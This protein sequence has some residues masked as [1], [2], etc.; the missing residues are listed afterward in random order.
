MRTVTLS[1]SGSADVVTTISDTATALEVRTAI[2]NVLTAAATSGTSTNPATVTLSAGEFIV[3]AVSLA[4]SQGVLRVGSNTV[5]QGQGMQSSTAPNPT[6]VKLEA[7][8]SHD[9]TGIIR[10]E[11]STPTSNVQIKNLTVD[12]NKAGLT[13]STLK[14]DGIY[15]GPVPGTALLVD[16]N[17][18][19]DGVEIRN[20]SR[21]GFDPHEQ[22]DQLVIKNSVSHHNGLDGFTIDFCTNVTLENN[23]SYANGQNGFNIVTSSNNV[24]LINNKAYS[25]S[26]S[27][28]AVQAGQNEARTITHDVRIVGGEVYGNSG[29]GI[30]VRQAD[31]VTV[32][33]NSNGTANGVSIHGNNLAG[34]L[35]EGS[36]NVSASNNTIGG[37]S[38]NPGTSA[39][40]EVRVKGYKQTYGDGDPANDLFRFS[41]GVAI[42]NNAIGTPVV[43]GETPAV[44][45]ISYTADVLNFATLPSNVFS[46]VTT[47][48][49]SPG[50]TQQDGVPLYGYSISS[51]ND[52]INGTAGA[53]IIAADSGNDIVNGLAGNDTL[54]GNDG[55]DILQGGAGA[56]NL[57]GGAGSDTASYAASASGVAVNLAANTASG[58]EA[59]GDIFTSIENLS[60]S[61]FADTLT[62][63]AG[64]N[65]IEGGAGDDVLTG[66]GNA[67][68]GDTVSYANSAAGITVSLA[69]LTLQGTKGAGFDTISGF[70]NLTGSAFADTLTGDS[71]NNVISGGDGDDIVDGG[72]GDDTLIA[73]NGVDT[74]SY[75]TAA[76]GVTISLADAAQ[77]ATGGAGNDKISDFENIV[78]SDFNDMLI[79][80]IGKN[81]RL[82]G[83]KG[84]DFYIVQDIGD[85]VFEQFG[86]G[87]DEVLASFSYTLENNV[88]DLLLGGSSGPINGTGNDSN[89]AL[90]GND[91]DNSL[92]GGKGD[93]YLD[94]QSGNDILD[95]GTGI[96]TMLG[97]WGNDT[98]Y[99]DNGLDSINELYGQGIDTVISSANFG[100]GW[101]T[102]EVENLTLTGTAFEAI[103]NELNNTLT[104]NSGNNLLLGSDGNDTLIGGGGNDTLNGGDGNDVLYGGAGNDDLF[105]GPNADR[106]VFNTALNAGTNNDDILDFELIDRIDVSRTFFVGIGP[107]NTTLTSDA[108]WTGTKAN[109]AQDRIIYTKGSNVSYLYYDKDGTGAQAAPVL[110]ARID[111]NIAPTHLDFFIIA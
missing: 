81:N 13:S 101:F 4:A 33:I 76:S 14:V 32:G 72:L 2:Q 18:T 82:S 23:T 50:G 85:V 43:A 24:T 46:G 58:G 97:G 87:R 29:S 20:M 41:D 75:A 79:G 56:D 7:G 22:T 80:A 94:G 5:F 103:G 105:G 9:V 60:G 16:S 73:G 109:D 27:G 44:I 34:L 1:V 111:G 102:S 47:T 30:S 15:T 55:D 71:G 98:Y 52:T 91:A 77:Q 90:E 74:L 104:G 48:I 36:N 89:N 78:G 11:S 110:F 37:N 57:Q 28:I 65:V 12:G 25:N 42:S 40:T 39:D 93:D 88:E 96:D 54:K 67:A 26:E 63:N 83:G 35:I 106:F 66:G 38:V 92:F 8:T 99:V 10:T 70:E 6:I 86:E 100:L 19:I 69:A 84:N 53:D 68:A 45:G 59:T 3:S 61:A 108:F 62:G 17:I 21:Y 95:G 64:D 107:A 49:S 51:G 31:N